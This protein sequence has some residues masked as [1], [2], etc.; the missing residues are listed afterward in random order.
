MT[1]DFLARSTAAEFNLSGHSMGA[2]L[3]M[4]TLRTMALVGHNDVFRKLNT[5][6]LISPDIEIDA[7]RKQA[8]PVLARGVPVQRQTSLWSR[9]IRMKFSSGWA[10][11]SFRT[12]SARWRQ[13]YNTRRPH[14]SLGYKPPAP[15]AVLWPGA[16]RPSTMAA[17]PTMH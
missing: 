10:E 13:H 5:V 11:F 6:L 7:F 8:E 4:D 16:P 14:S 17:K 3:L 2:F 9:Q 15:P 12:A 1:I